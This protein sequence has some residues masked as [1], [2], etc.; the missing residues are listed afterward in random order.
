M[1]KKIVLTFL[2]VLPLSSCA[3]TRTVVEDG[4]QAAEI[5]RQA[6]IALASA[7]GLKVESVSKTDESILYPS[8]AASYVPY[9]ETK[10]EATV[11]FFDE[12]LLGETK[13]T[14]ITGTAKE[15]FKSA[16]HTI[17]TLSYDT[18]VDGILFAL[19]QTV[20]YKDGKAAS[21]PSVSGELGRDLTGT[22]IADAMDL[23]KEAVLS[24]FLPD[25]FS[26]SMMVTLDK[27]GATVREV[28]TAI[29]SE[30]NPLY[31]GD[32]T[33]DVPVFRRSAK[34]YRFD[35][36]DGAYR[37]A[38]LRLEE[39]ESYATD[40][41]QN[42]VPDG[43][44]SQSQS[45]VTFSYDEGTW[46]DAVP[47]P[48]YEEAAIHDNVPRVDGV[49]MTDYSEG[50]QWAT[51]TDDFC[52]RLKIDASSDPAIPLSF[53]LEDGTALTGDNT[54]FFADVGIGTTIYPDGSVFVDKRPLLIEAVVDRETGHV[55]IRFLND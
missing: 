49:P 9:S 45:T 16:K 54:S 42:K 35:L 48:T 13:E 38:S 10:G 30:S 41:E 22:A 34:E 55:D 40:F 44:T 23:A 33:M 53:S 29:E 43:T 36:A 18:G 19:D 6:R 14:A 11:S 52:Y 51:G 27:R 5:L 47:L 20:S 8:S 7:T 21:I 39:S 46:D 15:R 50:Y 26:S 31:P 37:F 24:A 28:T 17:Q 12:V 25:A 1:K 32:S 3:T 4:Y 2:A